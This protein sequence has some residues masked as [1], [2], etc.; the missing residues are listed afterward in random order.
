MKIRDQGGGSIFEHGTDQE[1]LKE[2]SLE[3]GC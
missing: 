1:S 2:R 3:G